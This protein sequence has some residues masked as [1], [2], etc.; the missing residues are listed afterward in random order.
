MKNLRGAPLQGRL[1]ALL[2]NTRQGWKCLPWTNT[3]A[4]YENSQITEKKK[5]FI[6]GTS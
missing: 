3:L 2:T 5:F 6:V 4:Y 1:L